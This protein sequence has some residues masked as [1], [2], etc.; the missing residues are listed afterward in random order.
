MHKNDG[1]G[2]EINENYKTAIDAD[3]VKVVMLDIE[4]TV[5]D[6]SDYDENNDHDY[7]QNDYAYNPIA[8]N[9]FHYNENNYF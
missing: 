8:M 9:P 6:E 3:A 5:D 1:E 7:A 4:E 2:D